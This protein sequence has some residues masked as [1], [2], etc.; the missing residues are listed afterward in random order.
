MQ[1][2]LERIKINYELR[3]D[4]RPIIALHGY[5]TDHRIMLGCLEPA[6]TDR[7]GWQRIYL[8]LPGMGKTPGENWITN[9]DKMLDIVCEFIE[10][11]IPNQRFIL[12]GFSYGGYLARGIIQRKG[13]L[14][15]GLLMICPMVYDRNKRDLPPKNILVRDPQLMDRLSPEEKDEFEGWVAVQSPEIWKRTREEV[16]T[17]SRLAEEPFLTKLQES[18]YAFTFDVD[19]HNAQFNK[20]TLVLTGRQDWIVGYRDMWGLIENYPR[21]TFAVIDRAGHNLPIEQEVLFN[22]LVN[23]WLDRVEETLV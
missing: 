20:P 15:D 19:A 22:T 3:G 2:A 23:E 4:G 12:A 17:G 10:K 13:G 16:N 7:E 11:I 9:S 6:L 1:L 21:A 5:W 14:V 18:G 8:D